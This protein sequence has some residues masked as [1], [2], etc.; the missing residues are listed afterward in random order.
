MI[1]APNFSLKIPESKSKVKY[2]DFHF[3]ILMLVLYQKV[4]FEITIFEYVKHY[5][6]K[7]KCIHQLSF[8]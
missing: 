1:L 3:E 6:Q 7:S 2:T 8:I 5:S 4:V